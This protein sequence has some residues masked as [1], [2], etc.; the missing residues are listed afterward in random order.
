M[1]SRYTVQS[2]MLREA[3]RECRVS[4][5]EYT[6]LYQR[7]LSLAPDVSPGY[8]TVRCSNYF[9]CESS[10]NVVTQCNA[11]HRTRPRWATDQDATGFR[12]TA[13]KPP[14]AVRRCLSKSCC[15]LLHR[16]CVDAIERRK[17]ARADSEGDEK[18]RWRKMTELCMYHMYLRKV[19]KVPLYSMQVCRYITLCVFAAP[20]DTDK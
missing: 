1:G 18:D 12:H 16:V 10:L 4:I 15:D 13:R 19:H 3:A 7:I 2:A 20:R 14:N 8:C 6:V 9:V 17:M 5:L 11:P